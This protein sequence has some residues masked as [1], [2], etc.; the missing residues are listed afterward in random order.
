MIKVITVAD[1]SS[2]QIPAYGQT[3]RDFTFIKRKKR[4]NNKKSLNGAIFLPFFVYD[5]FR[6]QIICT[7][8]ES[9]P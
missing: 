3:R 7:V 1:K 4:G 2:P 8:T 6:T 5:I 9:H